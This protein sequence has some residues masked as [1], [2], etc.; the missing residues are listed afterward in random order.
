[1]ATLESVLQY[2]E[3]QAATI[4]DLVGHIKVVFPKEAEPNFK[5]YGLK[6]YFGRD[7][8]S[9]VVRNKI[10]PIYTVIYRINMDLVFNRRLASRQVFSDAKGISY[11]QNLLIETFIN[12]KNNGAFKDSYWTPDV[13]M[14]RPADSVVLRGTLTVVT[15]NVLT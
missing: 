2:I 5:D 11:W 1:M 13:E 8:W 9:E 10:G 7:D 12:Q 6:V 15:Q 3:T 14:D 4:S